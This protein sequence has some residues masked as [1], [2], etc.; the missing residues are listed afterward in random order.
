M[1]VWAGVLILSNMTPERKFDIAFWVLL[2]MMN[3]SLLLPD[4]WVLVF[5]VP[6]WA[7][8]FVW[9]VAAGA[10]WLLTWRRERRQGGDGGLK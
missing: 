4:D 5:N 3:A 9:I 8:I 10:Y 2:A 6:A 7:G 1:S